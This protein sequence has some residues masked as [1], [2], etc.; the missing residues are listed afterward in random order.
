MRRQISF[1]CKLLASFVILAGWSIGTAR[2]DS[3]PEPEKVFIPVHAAG[4]ILRMAALV[5]KPAGEGPFPV[6]IFSHGRSPKVSER[7]ALIHPILS[8]HAGY[9]I[10]KGFAILAPIRPGYGETGGE[11]LEASGIKIS[12][13]GECSGNPTYAQVAENAAD[14]IEGEL[15]WLQHQAWANPRKI[16]LVGQSVGGMAT[17]A[18]GARNLS[19]V[20][21]YINFSG[22]TGGNPELTPSH[23]CFPEALTALYGQFGRTTKLPNL[24][25]Y[26]QNDLFWGETAP[27]IWH[28]AFAKAGGKGEFVETDPLPSEDGHQL[29]AKGGRLW[30]QHVDPFI[31]SLG[32]ISANKD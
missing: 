3:V 31:A 15:I 10:K 6:I 21:A 30:S 8:G 7:S 4:K 1:C 12:K 19:G 5:Y 24:W 20:I 22:G 17:V 25:L 9:W 13:S 29:L 28:A 16:I 11:D 18:A 23:S 14:A 2:A 26:A 27:K 32:L